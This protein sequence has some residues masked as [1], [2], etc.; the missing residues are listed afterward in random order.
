MATSPKPLLIEL[1]GAKRRLAW[2]KRAQY[3]LGTL[4]RPPSLHDLYDEKKAAAAFVGILWAAI[5]NAED[6]PDPADVAVALPEDEEAMA[7][8]R[9]AFWSL[10]LKET[11][12]K[13]SD[14]AST[15]PLPGSS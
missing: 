8:I 6:L 7:T 10:F 9:K 12:P 14:G 2:N 1:A 11:D 5:E 3:R 15:A 4:P 13:K